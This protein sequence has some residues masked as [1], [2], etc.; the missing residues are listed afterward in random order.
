M[1]FALPGMVRVHGEWGWNDLGGE[2]PRTVIAALLL[3]AGSVI[4]TGQLAEISWGRRAP[5]SATASLR[6]PSWPAE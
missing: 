1:W 6:T 5:R 2:M 3:D 4:S